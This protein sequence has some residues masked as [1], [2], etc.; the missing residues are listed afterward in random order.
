MCVFVQVFAHFSILTA[1]DG[2]HLHSESQQLSPLLLQCCEL[3]PLDPAHIAAV[4]V[5]SGYS[6]VGEHV[7]DIQATSTNSGL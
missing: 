7:A 3:S 6:C 4:P 1:V 2:V 5:L